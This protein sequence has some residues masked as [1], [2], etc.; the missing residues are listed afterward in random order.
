MPPSTSRKSA[1]ERTVEYQ[2][3]PGHKAGRGALF[4]FLWRFLFET[5]ICISFRALK[6]RWKP[7]RKKDGGYLFWG[8]LS[9]SVGF[10]ILKDVGAVM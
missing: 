3:F 1:A 4:F 7:V 10:V 9:T 5:P 6:V 2:A 8:L